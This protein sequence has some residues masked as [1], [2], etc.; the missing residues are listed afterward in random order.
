MKWSGKYIWACKNYDGDVQSDTVAQGY[1]SLGLM[2]SVLLAPDGKTMEAEAAHGTVTRHYRIPQQG[3]ETSTNPIASIFAWTRGLAHRGKLD[4]KAANHKQLRESQS[5]PGQLDGRSGRSIRESDS[6]GVGTAAGRDSSAGDPGRAQSKIDQVLAEKDGIVFGKDTTLNT[7]LVTRNGKV[8][9]DGDFDQGSDSWWLSNKAEKG[10]TSFNTADEVIEHYKK[11]PIADRV[12]ADSNGVIFGKDLEK[13]IN[14]VIKDGKV[15]ATGW[16]E[17]T[18]DA[19]FITKKGETKEL[20]FKGE[21]KDVVRH[22]D[23]TPTIDRIDAE[24]DGFVFGKDLQKNISV[25]TKDGKVKSTGDFDFDANSWWMDVNGSQRSFSTPEDVI[26]F[27]K[28]NSLNPNSPT[29][30]TQGLW[31][32]SG[33]SLS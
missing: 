30:S 27:F 23:D 29:R 6:R 10:Q 15:I 21:A 4:E 2:T 32:R 9:A 17:S 26:K 24:S 1:G 16:Y 20:V 11:T 22:F 19:W 25:L 13:D 7:N 12:L 14:V 3:K 5:L 33:R 8:V 28:K 18:P 31:T